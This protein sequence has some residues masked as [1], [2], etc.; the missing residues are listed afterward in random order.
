MANKTL[1]ASLRDVLIPQTDTVAQLVEHQ[2]SRSR[3]LFLQLLSP[4]VRTASRFRRVLADKP[5]LYWIPFHPRMLPLPRTVRIPSA[6]STVPRSAS[7]SMSVF[8]LVKEGL[9]LP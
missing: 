8:S 1:F 9:V 6:P 5:D 2:I 7:W 3:V 4:Q